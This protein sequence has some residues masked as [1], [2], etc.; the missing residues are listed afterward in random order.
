VSGV[1]ESPPSDQAILSSA[2]QNS[3]VNSLRLE[4]I[5]SD[6]EEQH[7]LFLD[8]SGHSVLSTSS[9]VNQSHDKDTLPN[10]GAEAKEANTSYDDCS[11]TVAKKN[12][13]LT[14]S[15]D[16]SNAP[17]KKK[18]CVTPT[19][20]GDSSAIKMKKTLKK[21]GDANVEKSASKGKKRPKPKNSKD[22]H[23]LTGWINPFDVGAG[24]HHYDVTC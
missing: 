21:N 5:V 3:S 22:S 11:N 20:N 24:E 13:S 6:G 12:H 10:V 15:G 9:Y 4:A 7:S 16:N 1:I 19:T 14:T 17:V 23:G 8:A 2:E 18:H